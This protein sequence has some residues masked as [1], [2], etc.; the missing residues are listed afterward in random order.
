MI[1][2]AR[3]AG[4]GG[5]V[6]VFVALWAAPVHR[7]VAVAQ[8]RKG[9]PVLW[10]YGDTN[11]E[12]H[13]KDIQIDVSQF[14]ALGGAKREATG[15]DANSEPIKTA[16]VQFRLAG[17]SQNHGPRKGDWKTAPQRRPGQYMIIL[18]G[19]LEVA[20]TDGQKRVLGPG[21]VLL[22]DDHYSKGH[23]SRAITAERQQ[24]FIPLMSSPGQ[25][26]QPPPR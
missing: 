5:L 7:D 22:E 15:T 26:L 17:M 25:Q 3:S 14:I 18:K 1:S 21:D 24:L 12:T 16:G 10:M 11:G 8:A 2:R 13:L 20:T 9:I 6:L 23:Y 4:L 19:Q